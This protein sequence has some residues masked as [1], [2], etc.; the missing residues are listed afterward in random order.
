MMTVSSENDMRE[1]FKLFELPGQRGI[2]AE[3]LKAR[4]SGAGVEVLEEEVANIVEELDEDE[5]GRVSYDEYKR[6]MRW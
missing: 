2:S 1:S 6:L 4:L 5:D 3:G